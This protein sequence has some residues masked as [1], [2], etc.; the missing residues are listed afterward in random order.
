MCW[1]TGAASGNTDVDGGSFSA[2]AFRRVSSFPGF[3][4]IF[5]VAA[6]GKVGEEISANAGNPPTVFGWA[7]KV[8]RYSSQ[9]SLCGSVCFKWEGPHPNGVCPYLGHGWT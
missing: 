2:D 9:Y 5:Q 6:D 3:G 7:K 4:K 8:L 1:L